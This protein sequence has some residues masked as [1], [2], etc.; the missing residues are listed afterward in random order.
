MNVF[1]MS[2]RVYAARSAVESGEILA[3]FHRWIVAQSF[4]GHTWIDVADYSH[5]KRGP[6]IVL[7]GIEA[8]VSADEADGTW[9][10]VY[11]RKQPWPGSPDLAGRLRATMQA[12]V[13]C[14]A[15]LAA[16]PV[17]AGRLDFA[18][19]RMLIRFNDRLAAPNTRETFADALPAL[20]SAGESIWGSSVTVEH[21]AAPLA[22]FEAVIRG[23]GAVTLDAM[24]ARQSSG[25]G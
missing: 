3:A 15:V 12:A 1:K 14:A 22:L 8:N 21:R 16:D 2:A 6:G 7:V 20:T 5:V 23:G 13:Q 17:F 10:V 9:G 18:G 11:A 24:L 25:Q 19:D 4:A